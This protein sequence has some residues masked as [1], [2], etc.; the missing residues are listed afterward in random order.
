MREFG[1]QQHRKWLIV[2]AVS[3]AAIGLLVAAVSR[4]GLFQLP[5]DLRLGSGKWRVFIPLASCALLSAILT[6]LLWLIHWLKH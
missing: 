2:A 6:L 4:A 3:I 1:P 5:G